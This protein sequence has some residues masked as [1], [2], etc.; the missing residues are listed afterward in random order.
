M[1]I[2]QNH[3]YLS[4]DQFH[5]IKRGSK[6]IRKLETNFQIAGKRKK[7]WTIQ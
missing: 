6:E 7:F 5:I 3:N 2:F 4:K 1:I